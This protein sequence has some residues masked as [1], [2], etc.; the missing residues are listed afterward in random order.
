MIVLI[1][2]KM[3]L[4]IA[5]YSPDVRKYG[6]ENTSTIVAAVIDKDSPRAIYGSDLGKSVCKGCKNRMLSGTRATANV[7]YVA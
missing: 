2:T 6:V 3:V 1:V 4:S 7:V 5:E